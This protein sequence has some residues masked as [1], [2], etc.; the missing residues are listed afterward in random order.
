LC[1]KKPARSLLH[2]RHPQSSRYRKSSRRRRNSR[3][4]RNSQP[5]KQQALSASEKIYASAFSVKKIRL[6]DS[7]KISGFYIEVD[8]ENDAHPELTAVLTVRRS[9]FTRQDWLENSRFLSKSK[10]WFLRKDQKLL[11]MSSFGNCHTVV[12]DPQ[13]SEMTAHG[14]KKLYISAH[15]LDI[16]T[17]VYRDAT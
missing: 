6:V 14:K 8:L 1:I 10:V 5:A 12:Y 17:I 11:D 3:R 9:S 13:V 2:S 16:E 7:S 15:F 4:L